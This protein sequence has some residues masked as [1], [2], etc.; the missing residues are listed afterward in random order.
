MRLDQWLWGVRLYRTRTL[1]TT[2][3]RAGHVTV[4]GTTPKPAHEVRPGQLVAA[5]TGDITRTYRVIGAPPS[6]VGAPLV[7]L[8]AEDLT[9]PG[10]FLR[11][12]EKAHEQAYRPRGEGRPTKR[13]RRQMLRWS[14]NV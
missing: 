9:P 3:I 13:D 6:R 1:A 12:K 10:E 2:E 11:Q 8:Y 4:D 14:G 5:R 7:P